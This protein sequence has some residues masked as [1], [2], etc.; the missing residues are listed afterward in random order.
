MTLHSLRN[1]EGGGRYS[2]YFDDKDCSLVILLF[3]KQVFLQ[4]SNITY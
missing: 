2:S 1:Q 4:H 3:K